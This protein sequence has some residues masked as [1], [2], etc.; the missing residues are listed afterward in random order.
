MTRAVLVALLSIAVAGVARAQDPVRLPAVQTTAAM[1]KPHARAIVGI[2]RDTGAVPIEGVELS[3]VDL[4]RRVFAGVDGKFRFND[5]KPGEYA[6]RARKVGYA[7]QIRTVTVDEDGGVSEFA[8]LPVPQSL[9]PVVVSSS[10]GG[11]GGIVG[12]T[13][14]KALKGAVVRLLG[15]GRMAETD[16][17]GHFFFDVRP[18][19]Y[20]IGAKQEGFADRT[21]MVRV[22]KDSGRYVAMYLEPRSGKMNPRSAH[23][24]ED[25]ATRMASRMTT[26]S[27]VYSTEDLEKLGVTWIGDAIQNAVTR[28]AARAY[29]VDTDCYAVLNGG[30][31]IVNIN[32]LTRDDIV[33]MEVYP[34]ASSGIPGPPPI[35]GVQKSSYQARA[36]R[37][38]G[39]AITGLTNAREAVEA[40][41]YRAK[42]CPTIYVWKK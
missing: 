8:L 12:D 5:I 19:Q 28:A 14:Y 16:S 1:E 32:D 31:E 7:P 30:P 6:V 34:T 41:G 4:K 15:S 23:N 13:S 11:L 2:A 38:R 9:Q 25:L 20:F 33:S 3:I 21:L 26:N 42:R 36:S 22:P 35:V 18:G 24:M 10:R 29:V 40:N 39:T 27:S 17:T 37:F